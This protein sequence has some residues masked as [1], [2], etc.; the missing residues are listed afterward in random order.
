M[1]ARL[2][3]IVS[4]LSP[5]T[6]V[7]D[8]HDV[9]YAVHVPQHVALAAREGEPLTVHT[10]THVREDILQLYG[11]SS[12]RDL[13]MFQLLLTV[14]GIGPKTALG[15]MDKGSSAVVAAIRDADTDF[16][17]SVPRLGKKNAQK[18]II[19]LRT[20]LGNDQAFDV[21]GNES[22]DTHAIVEALTSM[23]FEKSEVR[24]VLKKLPT[25]GSIEKK[26]KEALRHLSRNP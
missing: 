19:E 12:P 21:T 23:G 11:F 2:T 3:G 25:E 22:G 24:D 6:L 10:Y 4:V 9:G 7:L 15:V 18:I 14:S 8:V 17:T 26:I 13:S 5:D 20:K 16:F 1:I